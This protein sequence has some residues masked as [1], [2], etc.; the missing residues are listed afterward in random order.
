MTTAIAALSSTT[1]RSHL[2]E[3]LFSWLAPESTPPLPETKALVESD[4]E[5]RPEPPAEEEKADLSHVWVVAAEIEVIPKIA[6]V[7]DYRGS[8]KATE[9]Q[10][11]DALEVYCK[12]CRRPYDEVTGQD[13]SAKIDNRH[14]IG[15]DQSTRAKRK[16]PVPPRNARVVPGGRIQRRGIEA[17]VGGVSRPPR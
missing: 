11:I 5:G 14:L 10:R 2:Q 17:Y 9:G 13:C 15:G 6:K 16:I 1:G 3:S 4:P 12:G 8:F 7:A